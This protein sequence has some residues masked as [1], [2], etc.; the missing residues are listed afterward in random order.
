MSSVWKSFWRQ[1][2][3]S[4]G[5]KGFFPPMYHSRSY[6]MRDFFFFATPLPSASRA[7]RPAGQ[8]AVWLQFESTRHGSVQPLTRVGRVAAR[9]LLP[10]FTSPLRPHPCLASLLPSP[11]ARQATSSCY[12][13]ASSL[14]E[15][16]IF[17]F[18]FHHFYLKSVNKMYNTRNKIDMYSFFNQSLF[19]RF[20]SSVLLLLAQFISFCLVWIQFQNEF[21]LNSKPGSYV[22]AGGGLY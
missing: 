11:L 13:S 9:Q 14:F 1:G 7:A 18:P 5:V 2:F 21:F 22:S 19:F 8:T 12:S 15:F 4:V 16:S 3:G 10:S 6:L 17:L 20:T